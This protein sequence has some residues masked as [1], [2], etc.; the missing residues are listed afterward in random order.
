MAEETNRYFRAD[1]NWAI[2]KSRD[3]QETNSQIEPIYDLRKERSV[4]TCGENE[5]QAGTA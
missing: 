1:Y 4:L 5:F 2:R 3:R